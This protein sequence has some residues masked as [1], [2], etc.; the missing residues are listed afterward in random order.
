MCKKPLTIGVSNRVQELSEPDRDENYFDSQ[1]IPFKKLIELDKIICQALDI[2]SRNSKRV[3][4]EYENLIKNF[5]EF[6]ILLNVNYEQLKT[7][8]SPRIVEGIKRVREGNLKITPG[9]DGEYGKVEI[10]S[11]AEKQRQKSLF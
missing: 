1:R 7:I 8:T 11:K 9:F 5:T 10:F 4:I 3:Q 6:D 2:K